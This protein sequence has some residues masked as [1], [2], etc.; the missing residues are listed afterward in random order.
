VIESLVVP[1]AGA[2][3]VI[4]MVLRALYRRPQ[5]QEVRQAARSTRS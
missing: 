2:A 3:V 1:I 4:T 5:P